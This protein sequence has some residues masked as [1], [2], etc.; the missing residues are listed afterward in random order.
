MGCGFTHDRGTAFDARF[1]RVNTQ[2]KAKHVVSGLHRQFLGRV[3]I[4]TY[5]P[6]LLGK[7]LG[8]ALVECGMSVATSATSPPSRNTLWV[9]LLTGL[10]WVG[11]AFCLYSG[12]SLKSWI[13]DPREGKDTPGIK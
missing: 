5:H 3:T 10:R 12:G 1:A 13:W 2:K 7:L 8:I 4:S 9:K 11:K 6:G